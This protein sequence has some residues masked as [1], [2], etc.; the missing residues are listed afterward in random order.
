MQWKDS[1]DYKGSSWNQSVE[2]VS[3]LNESVLLNEL[4]E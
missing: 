3:F 2:G 4:V 1:M